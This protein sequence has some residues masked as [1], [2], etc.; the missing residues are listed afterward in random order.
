MLDQEQ[1][2]FAHLLAKGV[3]GSDWDNGLSVQN[4]YKRTLHEVGIDHRKAA[5]TVYDL[6]LE[7]RF[8][9]PP[10]W[11]MSAMKRDSVLH[12]LQNA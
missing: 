1:I 8:S 11:L 4:D 2:Q 6:L 10:G 3:E 5:N 12:R 9:T 7:S